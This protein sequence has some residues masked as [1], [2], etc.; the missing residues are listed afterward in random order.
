MRRIVSLLI[1][2]LIFCSSCARGS[3]AVVDS[4]KEQ[5]NIVTS[6]T[7]L[8]DLVEQIGKDKV[9]V[10][11]LFGP[12]IDPH[13][14][15]PTGG[16]TKSIQDADLVVFTGLDLEAHFDQILR[17]YSDK[18]I[19]VGEHLDQDKLIRIEDTGDAFDPHYWFSV[20]LWSEA[21]KI[22]S[23]A[24][25]NID[26]DGS[27]FYEANTKAYI[28]ELDDLHEWT[29]ERVNK[30]EPS[31]RVLVTAHDAFHYFA[32][33]YDFEV[34]AIGGIST[35][36]EV[37]TADVNMAATV[38]VEQGVKSIFIESTMPQTTVN[39]VIREVERRGH[40]VSIGEELYSDALGIGEHARYIPAMK[41]N[42]NSIVEGLKDE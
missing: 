36:S 31:K 39:A 6:T 32:N 12:G 33:T 35:D 30:L 1:A 9:Q 16:D 42:V 8:G 4:D 3:T 19:L 5:V 26:P 28:E 24:L 20:P 23:Q 37:S 25:Q 27:A 29:I 34:A 41:H 2:L 10:T 38:I 17:A 13:L 7:M 15:M 14:A 11:M 18:T 40:T 21:A 22:V